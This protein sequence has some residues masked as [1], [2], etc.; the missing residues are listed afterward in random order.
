MSLLWNLLDY[1]VSA[2]PP[3]PAEA[4]SE[5]VDLDVNTQFLSPL[6]DTS[7]QHATHQPTEDSPSR[8]EH[9]ENIFNI[10]GMSYDLLNNSQMNDMS[11]MVATG[12]FWTFGQL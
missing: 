5:A 12:D 11:N 10:E 1:S 2:A 6:N 8:H 7:L 3:P 9:G 4:P